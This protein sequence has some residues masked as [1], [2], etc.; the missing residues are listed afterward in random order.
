MDLN[1]IGI[2]VMLEEFLL[3][4]VAIFYSNYLIKIEE[5]KENFIIELLRYLLHYMHYMEHI[6]YSFNYIKYSDY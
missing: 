2:A 1:L 3:I 6:N 5:K 4:N